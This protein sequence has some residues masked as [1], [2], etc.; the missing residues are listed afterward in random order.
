MTTK[1]MRV[2]TALM[3]E[4][5]IDY[6]IRQNPEDFTQVSFIGTPYHNANAKW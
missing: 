2:M 5:Y 4:S 1:E 6:F 3:M